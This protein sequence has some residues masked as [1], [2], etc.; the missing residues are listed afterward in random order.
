[1]ICFSLGP[2]LSSNIIAG[3]GFAPPPPHLHFS[4]SSIV[5]APLIYLFRR[6]V[7]AMLVLCFF[8]RGSSG[9]Q[10]VSGPARGDL[11]QVQPRAMSE[12]VGAVINVAP[13]G[14][15]PSLAAWLRVGRLAHREYVRLGAGA[16][17]GWRV[18]DSLWL[19]KE[20]QRRCVFSR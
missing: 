9:W 19:I 8:S 5:V 7:F 17:F 12:S 2:R 18:S 3:S 16:C 1:M 11:A 4:L 10:A 15:A 20:D 13:S 14:P 6:F